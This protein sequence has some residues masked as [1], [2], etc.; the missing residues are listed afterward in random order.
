MDIK[1]K[2]IDKK[3]KPDLEKWAEITIEKWQYNLA[4]ET[5]ISKKHYSK[6]DEP[7]PKKLIDSFFATVKHQSENDEFLIAFAFNYYIRMLEMGLGNGVT[8]YNQRDSKRKKHKVYSKTLY[9]ETQKLLILLQEYY[10]QECAFM[11]I[12]D[13]NHNTDS[14]T[15]YKGNK[16]SNTIELL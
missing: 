4:S 12:D 1:L 11:I 15:T 9:K 16:N 2:N 6:A 5:L 14:Y 10:L 7:T 13:F 8:L 3:A